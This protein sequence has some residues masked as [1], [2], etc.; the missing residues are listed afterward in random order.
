MIVPGGK[1]IIFFSAMLMGEKN[2][3]YTQIQ[4]SQFMNQLLITQVQNQS[5][6]N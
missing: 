5:H 4:V 1:V 2:K 6:I 3:K